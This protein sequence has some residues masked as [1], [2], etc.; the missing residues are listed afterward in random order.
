M[1][2]G[3]LHQMVGKLSLTRMA[4]FGTSGN[5]VRLAMANEIRVAICAPPHRDRHVAEISLYSDESPPEGYDG[6][7]HPIGEI[8]ID[9]D[10]LH[11]EIY[12]NK[13]SDCRTYKCKELIEAINEGMNR[14]CEMYPQE[15]NNG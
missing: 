2:H 13:E 8:T 4:F 10:Q 1:E 3:S 9:N 11:F 5:E 14:L 7:S 6:V 12:V 15:S